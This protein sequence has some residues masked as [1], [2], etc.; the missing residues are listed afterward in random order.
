MENY[1]TTNT[2]LWQ[3]HPAH[4]TNATIGGVTTDP[5]NDGFDLDACST[6]FVTF[7]TGNLHRRQVR[8]E[9]G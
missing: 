1:C 9:P 6:V 3:H 5:N 4:R 7:N 2:P 8:Q